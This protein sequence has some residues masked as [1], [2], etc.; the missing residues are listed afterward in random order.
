[1]AAPLLKTKLY[2]PPLRPRERVVSR[3]HL[4]ERLNA[5][6]ERS[7]GFARKLTLISAPVGFGKTTPVSEWVANLRLEALGS[8]SP[9]N[10]AMEE[11]SAI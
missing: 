8:V 3:P 1:M 7:G 9:P 6:L 5:G 2:I 10:E 11:K 4:I